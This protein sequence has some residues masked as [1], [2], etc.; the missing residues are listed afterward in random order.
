MDV[1]DV[2]IMFLGSMYPGSTYMHAFEAMTSALSGDW[3]WIESMRDHEMVGSQLV[4]NPGFRPN[5]LRDRRPILASVSFKSA[6]AK[7][8]SATGCT[9]AATIISEWEPVVLDRHVADPTR[10]WSASPRSSPSPPA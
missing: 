7:V 4:N 8:A 10:W 1:P 6:G 9:D 5:P 2:G 3:R